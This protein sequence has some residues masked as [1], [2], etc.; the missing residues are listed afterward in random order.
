MQSDLGLTP[1][2]D[3]RVIRLQV[4]QLTAVS[5]GRARPGPWPA[6]V[7]P[8]PSPPLPARLPCTRLPRRL[9]RPVCRNGARRW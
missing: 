4:P 1:N 3:G 6:A 7:A 8:L 2:N 5:G 9:P